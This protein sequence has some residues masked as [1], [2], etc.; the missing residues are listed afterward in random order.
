MTTDL[1]TLATM[2]HVLATLAF[3]TLLIWRIRRTG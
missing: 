2:S 3:I 1:L